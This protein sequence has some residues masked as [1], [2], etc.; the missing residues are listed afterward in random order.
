[1]AKKKA[2]Q[3]A[4]ARQSGRESPGEA[5]TKTEPD[6]RISSYIA[7]VFYSLNMIASKLLN[8]AMQSDRIT[9]LVGPT[10]KSFS[11]PE[12]LLMQYSPPLGRMC[13]S[14]FNESQ[15]RIIKLPE[16]KISTFKDFFIWIHVLEPSVNV[17]SLES[18]LD[19]AIFAEIYMIC[20]LKNQTSDILRAGF[21]DGRWELKPRDVSTVYNNVPSRSVIRQLCSV[22][23]A[24]TVQDR[25]DSIWNSRSSSSSSIRE[26]TDPL[27]WKKVFE[28]HAELG[29]DYFREVQTAQTHSAIG[30]G[31]PCRFHDHTDIHDAISPSMGTCPYP[32]PILGTTLRTESKLHNDCERLP[33]EEKLV[34]AAQPVEEQPVEEEPVEEE[35]VEEEPVAEEP[36]EEEPVEEEPVEEEPVEEEPVEEEPVEEEPVEEE[37]VEE[38]PVEEEPVEEEPVEEEPVEEE[39]V[40][41]EP[42]EEAPVGEVPVEE[43]PVEE[44]P[45]E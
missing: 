12:A 37:P 38:E 27:K 3:K 30:F 31:G 35:P 29:W 10:E 21:G 1:M 4:M 9:I 42:V 39:P 19:L 22:S 32:C 5:P 40:E 18:V 11:I 17:Q 33:S 36:V 15:T 2:K 45:V 34:K 20:H 41:E 8:R 25:P 13:Q 6:L 43:V 44:V 16:V 7:S 24:L 23:L 14:E 26:Y 28:K